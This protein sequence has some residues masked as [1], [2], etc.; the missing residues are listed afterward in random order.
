MSID[1]FLTAYLSVFRAFMNDLLVVLNYLTH[2]PIKKTITHRIQEFKNLGKQ[3]S[4]QIFPRTLF[5][6]SY[7]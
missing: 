5:L 1:R 4:E 2:S 3:S 6:S 7:C